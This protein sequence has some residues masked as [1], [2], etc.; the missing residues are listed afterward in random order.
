MVF[1]LLLIKLCLVTGDG[2]E[3]FVD[4]E[5]NLFDD[6]RWVVGVD[7]Y[8]KWDIIWLSEW[9]VCVGFEVEFNVEEFDAFHL[10]LH[11]DF[12]VVL[13]EKFDDVFL[14]SVECGAWYVS[15]C[16][17]T[18]IPIQAEV[19]LGEVGFH[20]VQYEKSYKFANFGSVWGSHS[21]VEHGVFLG[22]YFLSCVVASV[23]CARVVCVAAK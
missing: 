23:G 4:G 7:V 15:M 13:F 11:G 14:Y 3:A 20:F 10:C 17:K 1:R 22:P 2:T 21:H 9:H 8:V 5:W 12:E 19:E 18:V 16:G 6:R